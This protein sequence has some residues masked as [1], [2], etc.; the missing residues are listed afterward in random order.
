MSSRR[1]LALR[2]MV[3]QLFGAVCQEAAGA[4][5]LLETVTVLIERSR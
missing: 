3:G 1:T 4:D 5:I 2:G